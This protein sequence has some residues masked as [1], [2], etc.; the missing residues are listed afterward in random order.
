MAARKVIDPRKKVLDH[1]ELV[2]RKQFSR[3]ARRLFER[4][5][6]LNL[7]YLSNEQHVDYVL[8]TGR[9]VPMDD[10]TGGDETTFNEMFKIAR[11][12]RAKIM[13][14]SPRPTALPAKDTDQDMMTARVLDAYFDQ[15]MWD[16]NF[17][18]RFRTSTFWIVATGNVFYHWYWCNGLDGKPESGDN[19]MEVV[20]PFEI[21]PDPYS[22][23]WDE[24]RY[25]IHSK[26]MS[27]ENAWDTYG[28]IAGAK[29][30]HIVP[31]ASETLSLV[32]RRIYSDLSIG[33]NVTGGGEGEDG[34]TVN[35]YYEPPRTSFTKGRYTVYTD[36]GIILD[37]DYPYAHGQLPFTH[38]GHIERSSSKWYASLCD[39]TRD[40]QDELNRAEAQ[41]IDN[42]NMSQGKWFIPPQIELDNMPDAKP[43]QII[44]V[45]NG[46]PGV[47]PELITPNS[48]PAWVGNEPDR[49]RA[50]MSNLAQQH[51]VSQGGVP[52]RVE[53]GQAIQLLQE[54][55][56]SVLKDTVHSL[57]EA[58]SRGFWQCASNYV[59]YG[60]EEKLVQTYDDDG[61]VE[62]R[63]LLKSRVDL[64]FRVR[65]QIATSLPANIAGKWDRVLNL[66]QYQIIAP[67]EARKLLEL[68]IDEPSL[69]FTLKD[70]KSAIRENYTMAASD[71]GF[72]EGT[73][74]FA[75][76]PEKIPVPKP[77]ENHDV[78]IFEH[79]E[80]MK[81][82]EFK[83]CGPHVQTLFQFHVQQHEDQ[84]IQRGQKMAMMQAAMQ[85]PAPAGEEAPP[86]APAPGGPPP[87]PAQAPDGQGPP[88]VAV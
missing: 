70:R 75:G 48:I 46:P 66:V 30:E 67:E 86:G 85:P 12:E 58:L 60:N 72:D 6:I 62:V 10:E 47:Y 26:H 18:S 68:T 28:D 37:M 42:R 9:L 65:V 33:G 16:W 44:K 57:Q 29:V 50:V 1:S 38:A 25:M 19:K 43:R 41:L 56:D 22:K 51:E 23:R 20:S 76:D 24:Q 77:W 34:I 71:I 11:L 81:T 59:Q 40:P 3:N 54:T 35:M 87:G 7:A 78:H 83:A 84:R 14:T 74:E 8:Q 79:E 49:I 88:E 36:S 31:T 32:E 21:F 80:F 61:T 45:L 15:L 39:Y 2:T 4:D 82:E 27:L 63:K 73:G 64:T 53:S 17:E 13:R 5:W 52:G 55:D 69:D